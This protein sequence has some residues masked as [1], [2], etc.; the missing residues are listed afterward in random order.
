MDLFNKLNN[1][2]SINKVKT[3]EILPQEKND[4]EQKL[5]FGDFVK[6]TNNNF[7]NNDIPTVVPNI[8]E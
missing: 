7:I 1:Q 8:K 3:F 4:V 5:I 2:M 6:N